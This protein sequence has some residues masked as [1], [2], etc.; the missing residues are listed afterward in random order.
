MKNILNFLI[1]VGKLK[2]KERRGWIVH[3]IKKPETTA[4]H[5]F[6]LAILA[7]VLGK[8]KKLNS[9]RVIK[10]ALIHDLCEV[11]APDL[12]P[13]DP[14]LPKDKKKIREVL[15]K[16][17]RFTLALK[18][19]KEKEKHKMETAAL[20]KLTGKLPQNL[21]MEMRSLWR[22]F[23]EGLTK[24]GRFVQQADKIAN[25]LQG[26]DFWKKYGKI[27]YK[28]WLRWIKEIVDDPVLLEFVRT[29]ENKFC[30]K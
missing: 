26:L 9:E 19:K 12:T 2:G 5:I 20:N 25:F 6:H 7:W 17:P 29:L 16:W 13:Y 8:S 22:E 24:E 4:E 11:Y 18:I 27:Q 23:E 15:E 21:K 3:Q 30:K 10:I 14:L 28:L 1:E